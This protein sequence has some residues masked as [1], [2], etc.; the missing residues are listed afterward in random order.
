MDQLHNFHSIDFETECSK[1]VLFSSC[2]WFAITELHNTTKASPYKE[3]SPVSLWS[4][5]QVHFFWLNFHGVCT[6]GYFGKLTTLSFSFVLYS[7][8]SPTLKC[9]INVVKILLSS[10]KLVLTYL[11][12]DF[13]L[14]WIHSNGCPP[15]QGRRQPQERSRHS[16]PQ[17]RGAAPPL[18]GARLDHH[19][20]CTTLVGIDL[21]TCIKKE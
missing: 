12:Y 18:V 20:T 2:D 19:N 8:Y 13:S 4:L 5:F 14:C 21:S 17:P 1:I 9:K 15:P 6:E 3:I 16:S 7:G 10:L 11:F